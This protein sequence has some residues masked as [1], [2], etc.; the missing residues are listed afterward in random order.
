MRCLSIS[1]VEFLRFGKMAQVTRVQ[2]EVWWSRQRVDLRNRF[3][4]RADDILIRVFIKSDVTVADLH[5][6]EIA[7]D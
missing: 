2:D 4:Q 5:K 6:T 1:R 7:A 3:L